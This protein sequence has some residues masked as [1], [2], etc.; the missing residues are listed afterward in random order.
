VPG[1]SYFNVQLFRGKTKILSAWP[2]VARLQLKK[3]WVYDRVKRTLAPGAYTWYVWPGLGNRA[4]T[5]YGPMLGKSTFTV[6]KRKG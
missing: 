1:A 4:E 6:V 5:R 2:T 3:G